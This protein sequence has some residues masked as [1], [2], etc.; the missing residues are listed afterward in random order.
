MAKE[1]PAV[2]GQVHAWI[3]IIVGGFFGLVWTILTVLGTVAA[4]F[5]K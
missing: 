4:V 3:G 2:R 1:N 5:H